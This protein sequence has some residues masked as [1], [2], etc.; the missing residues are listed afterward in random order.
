MRARAARPAGPRLRRCAAPE[1]G[2]HRRRRRTTESP[3]CK[4]TPTGSVSPTRARRLWAA[5]DCRRPPDAFFF[6]QTPLAACA[7]GPGHAFGGGGPRWTPLT[8]TA[9]AG[10]ERAGCSAVEARV[11]ARIPDHS[12][13]AFVLAVLRMQNLLSENALAS[14]SAEE[15]MKHGIPK[16]DAVFLKLDEATWGAL[17]EL[18]RSLQTCE[19]GALCS[20]CQGCRVRH[21]IYAHKMYSIQELRSNIDKVE[22]LPLGTRMHIRNWQQQ[23]QNHCGELEAAAPNCAARSQAVHDVL[24][25]DFFVSSAGIFFVFHAATRFRANA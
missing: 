2:Q 1:P 25:L 11:H 13:A 4:P 5:H 10:S 20:E 6:T 8:V 17:D 22:M 12:T 24:Q 9:A 16:S 14:V 23:P 18:C 7:A 3:S 21:A 15:L 19:N